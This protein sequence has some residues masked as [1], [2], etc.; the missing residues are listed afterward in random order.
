MAKRFDLFKPLKKTDS[1][2]CAYLGPDG[3][4]IVLFERNTPLGRQEYVKATTKVA[5]LTIRQEQTGKGQPVL[6]RIVLHDSALG[7]LAIP[8]A[9]G[10]RVRIEVWPNNSSDNTRAK[11]YVNQTIVVEVP[12]LGRFQCSEIPGL[13][14]SGFTLQGPGFDSTLGATE[15][16]TAESLRKTNANGGYW[17]YDHC[18]IVE[19]DD[20]V[21]RLDRQLEGFSPVE[22]GGAL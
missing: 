21:G 14:G 1:P 9:T 11:G 13:V 17:G 18:A 12:G 16:Q 7:L 2:R 22:A 20:P 5:N 15:V 10:K 4:C 3:S 6:H 8:L 19:F